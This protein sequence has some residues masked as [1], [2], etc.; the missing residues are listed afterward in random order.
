MHLPALGVK[1][2]QFRSRRAELQFL[3][4]QAPQRVCLLH[5]THLCAAIYR[6]RNSWGSFF[7]TSLRI[8][9]PFHCGSRTANTA[10]VLGGGGVSERLAGPANGS[11]PRCYVNN[12]WRIYSFD[13]HFLAAWC[14]WPTERHG[15]DSVALRLA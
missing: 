12:G 1:V 5:G 15:H 13:K 2:S 4:G 3:A 14:Q 6:F 10:V 7:R 9:S 11:G 8:Q